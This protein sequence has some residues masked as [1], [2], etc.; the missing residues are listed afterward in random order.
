M[1]IKELTQKAYQ[2]SNEKG[3]YLLSYNWHNHVYGEEWA[4]F[5][6][7]KEC[8][9]GYS[10][11]LRLARRF[12]EEEITKYKNSDYIPI[13]LDLLGIS[14]IYER[15]DT[16]NKNIKVLIEKERLNKLL[17]LTKCMPITIL[18]EKLYTLKDIEFNEN[19]RISRL[20]T[21]IRNGILVTSGK[22]L[23][24]TYYVTQKELDKYLKVVKKQIEVTE[25]Q[26]D[27]MKHALGLSY[28]KKP[29]R[30]IFYSST[31]DK[32]W[33]D[34][35]AKDLAEKDFNSENKNCYFWLSKL[36]VAFILGKSITIKKY[37]N[38]SSQQ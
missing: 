38:L 22:K 37:N 2:N 33:N 6:G 26:L 1:D 31:S 25:E 8:K 11:D 32:K 16:F 30:N 17:G 24:G 34:L 28:G 14:E 29:Y 18:G 9:N 23:L 13:P 12:T 10:S 19:I 4:V 21:D 3:L 20:R 36:G 27:E 7:N 15:E 5:L 35:V